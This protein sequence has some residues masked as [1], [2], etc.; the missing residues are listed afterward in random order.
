MRGIMHLNSGGKLLHLCAKVPQVI[1]CVVNLRNSTS[2]STST[3]MDR[4]Q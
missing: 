2:T 3:S 1:D 4:A